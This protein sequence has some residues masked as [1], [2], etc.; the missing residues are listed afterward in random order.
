M[1]PNEVKKILK[2]SKGNPG[3]IV[4]LTHFRNQ[5]LIFRL[6]ITRT[7]PLLVW[8]VYRDICSDEEK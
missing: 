7:D 5:D 6:Q 2:L 3:V 1:S 4:L 8:M